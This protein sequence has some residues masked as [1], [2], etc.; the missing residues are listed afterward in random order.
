V[1]DAG[2]PLYDPTTKAWDVVL[3]EL[4]QP[5]IGTPIQIA[6]PDES[7]IWNN[8]RSLLASG[9]GA[10]T[11]EGPYPDG[12]RATE[13]T[14]YGTTCYGHRVDDPATSFCAGSALG[15]R[16]TCYGDS[17]G[18]VAAPLADGGW[19]LVGD[20]SYG[21]GECG[22]FDPGAYGEL[23]AEPMRS[24][25]ANAAMKA[26]GA[27]IVGSGGSAPTTLSETQARENAWLWASDECAASRFCRSYAVS[28]CRAQGS[29]WLC[30][31]KENARD[32]R[33]RFTCA[34]VVQVSA[35]SASVVRD[36]LGKWKCRR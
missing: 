30:P 34:R 15:D 22:S 16:D 12:L 3:L 19:R 29:A 23:A 14:V 9:W 2:R 4:A 26:A 6:G 8:G 5:A 13:L 27:D 11:E 18:P 32:N 28:R 25:L 36:G 20:T 21:F 31:A 33:S 24:A 7:S 10:L 35:T 1:N 17:G